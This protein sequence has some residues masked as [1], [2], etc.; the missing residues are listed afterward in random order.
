[1]ETA[2]LWIGQYGYPA[3]FV[4]LTLGIVGLPVP[5][6]TLLAFSGYLVYQKN[7]QLL[8]TL[9]AAFLGAAC[10]ITISYGIGRIFGIPVIRKYGR[11]V[12]LTP[13]RFERIHEWFERAGKWTLPIGYFVPGVRHATA[14]LAGASRLHFAEFMVFAYTGAFV[15]T[16]VFVAIG[17]V[18]GEG[19]HRV[20]ALVGRHVAIIGC[21][22]GAVILIGILLRYYIVRRRSSANSY[23]QTKLDE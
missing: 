9:A 16:G 3:I 17:M 13:E 6:E 2:S 12:H 1:M 19:W 8:P 11:Y 20:P 15:W 4:L 14:V 18:L 5:D 23:D 22:A 7:L 10:G 21:G